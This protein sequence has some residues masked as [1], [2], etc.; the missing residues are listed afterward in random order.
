MNSHLQKAHRDASRKRVSTNA[1][2]DKAI[3]DQFSIANGAPVARVV[4]QGANAHL[5]RKGSKRAVSVC[6]SANFS[7]TTTFMAGSAA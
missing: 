1:H 3:T 6:P 7:V 4:Q 5:P 2:S